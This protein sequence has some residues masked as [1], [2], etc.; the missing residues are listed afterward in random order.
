MEN[1]EEVTY[2]GYINYFLKKDPLQVKTHHFKGVTQETV[3]K[4]ENQF[5]GPNYLY[6][7]SLVRE[8]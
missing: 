1:D 2:T 5:K 7:G 4:Y 3:D 8:D 6:V